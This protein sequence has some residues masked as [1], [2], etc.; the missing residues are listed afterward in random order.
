MSEVLSPAMR[1]ALRD[2]AAMPH[3]AGLTL[4][5]VIGKVTR[6]RIGVFDCEEKAQHYCAERNAQLPLDVYVVEERFFPR[7]VQ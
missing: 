1:Q 6:N 7:S 4:W 5:V 2:V 3:K